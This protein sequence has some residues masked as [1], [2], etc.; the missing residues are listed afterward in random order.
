MLALCAMV[1]LTA[2]GPVTIH[3]DPELADDIKRGGYDTAVT[4]ALGYAANLA[5]TNLGITLP[6]A[7]DATV[8]AP[9]SY[10]RAFGAAA[11]QRWWA[12]YSGGKIHINGGIA[13][14]GEFTGMLVHEMTHAVLDSAGKGRMFDTWLNEGLAEVF[15]H[16][17]TGRAAID[18]VQRLF[19]KDARRNG[20]IGLLT[21]VRAPLDA[22][23]YL[24]SFAAVTLLMQKCGRAKVLGFYRAIA[25]GAAPDEAWRAL[26]TDAAAFAKVFDAW[27]SGYQG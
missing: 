27:V 23:R 22:N 17:A 8:Y 4:Q 13:I 11:A 2:S 9:S 20:D 15:E 19:L 7:I 10:E 26:D 16:E 24:Q 18:D 3:W 21:S 14:D 6:R 12:H 25:T 1:V 5:A